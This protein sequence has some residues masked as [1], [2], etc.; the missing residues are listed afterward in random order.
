MTKPATPAVSSFCLSVILKARPATPVVF[1]ACCFVC[2]QLQQDPQYSPVTTPLASSSQQQ[3][4]FIFLLFGLCPQKLFAR[5]LVSFFLLLHLCNKTIETC[6]L[7][8]FLF[9]YLGFTIE[10]I[11]LQPPTLFFLLR[12]F[13]ISEMSTVL[14]TAFFFL[15]A[16]AYHPPKKN[17]AHFS[18]QNVHACFSLFL[19]ASLH[20]GLC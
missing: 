2:P 9:F 18:F 3:Y 12:H 8:S 13:K 4:S 5:R 15:F 7:H 17:W 6:I 19:I 16:R 14:C 10:T 11:P 20:A 1:H